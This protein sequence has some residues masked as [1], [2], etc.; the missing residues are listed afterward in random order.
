MPGE[1]PPS[2][3]SDIRYA[4]LL[5]LPQIGRTSGLVMTLTG[6]LKSILLVVT[7][8]LLW[9]TPITILQSLGYSIALAGLVHYS[10]GQDQLS[11]GYQAASTWASDTVKASSRESAARYH[12]YRSRCHHY[13]WTPERRRSIIAVGVMC[14]LSMLVVVG[15]WRGPAALRRAQDVVPALLGQDRLLERDRI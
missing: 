5:T 1:T 10:L 2:I 6:I 14:F 15:I 3:S 9:R 8:V 7:S 4:E 12:H 13:K 11:R